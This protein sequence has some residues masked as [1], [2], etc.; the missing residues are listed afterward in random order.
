M[1]DDCRKS[2]ESWF[3]APESWRDHDWE[4]W[5][6]AWNACQTNAVSV[7][8]ALVDWKTLSDHLTDLECGQRTHR[9]TFAMIKELLT[10]SHGWVK[11]VQLPEVD[12]MVEILEETI[13]TLYRRA[14]YEPSDSLGDQLNAWSWDRLK[15]ALETAKGVKELVS[16]MEENQRATDSCDFANSDTRPVETN[17]TD[18]LFPGSKDWRE[19]S[20]IDRELWL[21]GMYQSAKSELERLESYQDTRPVLGVEDKEIAVSFRALIDAMKRRCA[22]FPLEY[23]VET[24]T[25]E[26]AES[27][28]ERLITLLT[29]TPVPTD[30]GTCVWKLQAYGEEPWESDCGLA[31]TFPTEGTPDYHGMKFCPGCGKTLLTTSQSEVNHE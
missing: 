30:S 21:I 25:I 9:D 7:P 22:G 29:A 3:S 2:F 5:Q 23:E 31:W 17:L 6:A 26:T 8:S 28:V 16:L 11:S 27:T 19:G 15:H 14:T 12:E 1:S 13:D 4:L 24:A 18:D 10:T 20:R